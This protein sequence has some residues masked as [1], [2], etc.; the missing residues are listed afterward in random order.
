MALVAE[1]IPEDHG[2]GA[3][4]DVIADEL[5]ALLDPALDLAGLGHARKVALHVG[6][7]DRNALVRE[8]F[9]QTLQRYGFARAG[10]ARD[11]AVAIG[12]PEVDELGLD[13]LPDIGA[14]LGK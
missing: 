4:L 6:A 5:G 13:A 9:S 1:Q 3:E 10:R 11:Q 8:R 2:T 7:K 14:L 12:Q